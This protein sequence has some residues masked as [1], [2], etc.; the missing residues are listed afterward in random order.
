LNLPHVQAELHSG[1]RGTSISYIGRNEIE[2]LQVPVPSLSIQE[3]IEQVVALWRRRKWLQ[4]QI[5]AQREKYIQAVCRQAV[6]N[7]QQ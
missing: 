5:D 7:S 1:S 6:G 2:S 3:R 4:S